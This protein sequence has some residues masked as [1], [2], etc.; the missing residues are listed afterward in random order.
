MR[1]R[2]QEAKDDRRRTLIEAALEEFYDR[3]FQAARMDDIAA[4]AG[5]SKGALYLYFDSKEALFRAL[6]EEYA[7][8]N[9][10]ALKAAARA[11]EDPERAISTVMRMA[12]ALVRNSPVPKIV[13]VLI[14]VAPAYPELATLYREKVVEPAISIVATALECGRRSGVFQ[15]E[16][17]VMTARTVVAPFI[18]AAVWEMVFSHDEDAALDLDAL[19][20]VHERMV[21][22]ALKAGVEEAA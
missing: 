2:T 4:R 9:V 3:G 13:K 21:M 7:E 1:A 14:G 20:A 6:V 11:A 22:R 10:A 8:P 12:P 18:K 16:D 5:V 19:F 17:P 15:L